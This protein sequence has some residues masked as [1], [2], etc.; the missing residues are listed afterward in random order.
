MQEY[1]GIRTV[2]VCASVQVGGKWGLAT[3]KAQESAVDWRK[4]NVNSFTAFSFSLHYNLR[5]L[6]TAKTYFESS[7]YA[8]IKISFKITNE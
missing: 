7:R 6:I 5:A 4:V 3:T 1:W 8:Q 2:C